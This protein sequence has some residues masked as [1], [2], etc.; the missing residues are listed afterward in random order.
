MAQRP[1][2][3]WAWS[4]MVATILA[5]TATSIALPDRIATH[6]AID[7][8]ASGFMPRGTYLVA[9]GFLAVGVPA[10]ILLG[11]GG[12]VRRASTRV[13][14]P[15][16][17]YWLSP[18]RREATSEW[19]AQHTARLAAGACA[20][21]FAVHVALIRA[22]SF[23]PPRLEPVVSTGLLAGSLGAVLIWVYSFARRFRHR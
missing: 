19:L 14:I 1:G 23:V 12:A 22:N 16:R 18:E 15:D 2:T 10:L 21:A 17:D 13:K 8:H 4:V 5:V 6:F 11:V 9:M 7:G 20:F 3:G